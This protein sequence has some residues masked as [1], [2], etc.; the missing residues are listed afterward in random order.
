M[1]IDEPDTPFVPADK[2]RTDQKSRPVDA[3]E[4]KRKLLEVKRL[5]ELATSA[6]ADFVEKRREHYDEFKRAKHLPTTANKGKEDK[7]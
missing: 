3:E 2:P 1:K 6:E 4:L 7:K 5:E